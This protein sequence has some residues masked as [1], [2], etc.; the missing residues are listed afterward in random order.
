MLQV[1]VLTWSPS[2]RHTGERQTGN[3]QEQNLPYSF[4][5]ADKHK[6][7]CCQETEVHDDD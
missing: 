1:G 2:W 7:K 4:T 6:S 3:L 5:T